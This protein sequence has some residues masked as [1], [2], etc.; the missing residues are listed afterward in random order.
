VFYDAI[1]LYDAR[2]KF[3]VQ[4]ESPVPLTPDKSDRERAEEASVHSKTIVRARKQSCGA[5]PAPEVDRY[6]STPGI[7]MAVGV[8]YP[9]E[10][11]NPTR[12]IK[13]R[14]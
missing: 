7:K 8:W 6:H 1:S 9:D 14:D 12:E 5:Y 4:Q 3:H 2:H 11:G 10:F 13:A